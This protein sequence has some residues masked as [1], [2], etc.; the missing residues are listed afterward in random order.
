MARL[1]SARADRWLVAAFILCFAVARAGQF[2]ERDPYWQARAGVENLAGWPLARP[3]TWS[4][5]GVTGDWYQ[6][7]PL[8]NDLLGLAWRTAGF[9]GI[10]VVAVAVVGGYL[11]GSWILAGSLGGR[12]LPALAGMMATV[13]PVLAML[14]P[15]GTLA[16]QLIVLASVLLAVRAARTVA[17]TLPAWAAGTAALIAA[18][19][20]STLGNWVHLSF[21]LLGPAMAVLWAVVWLFTGA[22][23]S[24]KVVLI[25]AGGLGWA[26]GPVLSPYG[27][28]GGLARSRAVQEVCEGLILEWGGPFVPG[29]SPV[30]RLM[31]VATALAGLVVVI[32]L[33]RRWI[34]GDRSAE[35]AGLAALSVLGV[36]AAVAGMGAIR[37]LGV[38]MLSLSPVMAVAATAGVDALRRRLAER[39]ASRWREYSTGSFWRV[40]IV[41]VIVILAPATLYQGAKLAVPAE[42]AL[43]RTLPQGCTLF[44]PG[45]LAATA[46]LVRPDV[47]VWIDGRADFY[48]RD[49]LMTT[50]AYFG[51][52]MPTLV[53]PGA[54][55]VVM[56]NQ[57][58]DSRELAAA[59]HAS[60]AWR[61]AGLDGR[62]ELWLPA[63]S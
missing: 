38:A 58:D 35:F 28:A 33:A 27:L 23:V 22:P 3:D 1:R 39:P 11:A 51:L 47:Q 8:W 20:M 57:A 36:P 45:G 46:I 5:S 26:V 4:W 15:R 52:R 37:F 56:D 30:F 59:L 63:G 50:Y 25:V 62:F 48:G 13:S 54:S 9:A 60:R 14:S 55:C 21:L 12:G 24:R 6:N 49:H 2:E 10:F 19:G 32:W 29:I 40:V 16:A 17:L 7:S 31:A 18:A 53:P 61:L 44:A 34:A 42:T 41:A 43:I